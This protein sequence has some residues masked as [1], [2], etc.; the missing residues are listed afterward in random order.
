MIS[1]VLNLSSLGL[2]LMAWG[3]GMNALRK[4]RMSLMSFVLCLLAL[5]LQFAELTH[6]ATMGDTSAILD[7]ICAITLAAVTLAAGTVFL[8]TLAHFLGGE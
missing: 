8:N 1:G 2:G 3:F 6:R 7:T 4:R 5:I